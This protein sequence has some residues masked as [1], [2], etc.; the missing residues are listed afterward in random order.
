MLLGIMC[1]KEIVL[2]LIFKLWLNKELGYFQKRFF[3]IDSYDEGSICI[4]VSY[5]NFKYN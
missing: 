1:Y 3:F 2:K 5:Y 4:F